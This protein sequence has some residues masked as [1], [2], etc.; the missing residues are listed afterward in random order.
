MVITGV[1]LVANTYEC[2]KR[3]QIIHEGYPMGFRE[4]KQYIYM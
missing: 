3:P 2:T 4:P 1:S